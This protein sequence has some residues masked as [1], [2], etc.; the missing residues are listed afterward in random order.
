[1]KEAFSQEISDK[2]IHFSLVDTKDLYVSLETFV[3]RNNI[4]AVAFIAHK[5]NIFKSLF[6]HKITKNDFFKLGLPMIALH[7]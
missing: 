6:K 7:E 4:N 1:M 3:D 5:S 2:K